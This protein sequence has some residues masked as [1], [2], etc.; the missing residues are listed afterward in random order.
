MPY[1][2]QIT[3]EA[4]VATAREMIEAEGVD[5]LSLNRLS[6]ALGVKTPSLYHYVKNRTAL[7]RA[8]NE[9]TVSRLFQVLGPA[10]NTAGDATTRLMAVAAAYRAFVLANPATY[11]LVFTN[12]IAELR[13]ENGQQENAVMPLQDLMAEVSGDVD[14]LPALRGLWALV[15]GYAMLEQ[16]EQ[17]RRGGAID[18]AF[19]QAVAVYIR[20]WA[21]H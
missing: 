11:G 6:A 14:A 12:T 19:T 1:P 2:S 18:A 17:F 15:H 8:V 21:A 3:R 9:E 7:L 13:P 16:A 5:H 4:I 20:G 10:A